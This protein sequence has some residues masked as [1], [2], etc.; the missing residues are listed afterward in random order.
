[1][2]GYENKMMA[3]SFAGII[4]NQNPPDLVLGYEFPAHSGQ[5]ALVASGWERITFLTAEVSFYILCVHSFR[6][7][8]IKNL[9]SYFDQIGDYFGD[10]SA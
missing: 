10:V 5:N 3:G 8:W 1:M 4:F 2:L 6:L 7:N 9:H